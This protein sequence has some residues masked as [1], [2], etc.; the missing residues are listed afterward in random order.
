MEGRIFRKK[1]KN[2][3]KTLDFFGVQIYY[4]VVDYLER[5]NLK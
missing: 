1:R 5:H 2:D 4:Y 3:K